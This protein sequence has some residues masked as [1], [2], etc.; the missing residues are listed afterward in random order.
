MKKNNE[1]NHFQS[2]VNEMT[3]PNTR[4]INEIYY[5]DKRKNI[6]NNSQDNK[7]KH[8]MKYNGSSE[9]NSYN[10]I[11]RENLDKKIYIKNPLAN[12]N[13]KEKNQKKGKDKKIGNDIA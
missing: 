11:N 10:E 5:L 8:I 7:H 13:Y 1:R 4:K 2:T 3:N 6:M 9:F 12:S